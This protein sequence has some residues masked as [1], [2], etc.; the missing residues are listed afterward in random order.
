MNHA[1]TARA[2]APLVSLALLMGCTAQP[3]VTEDPLS[4]AGIESLMREQFDF[5]YDVEYA[6]RHGFGLI[7]RM[8]AS[9]DEAG[10]GENGSPNAAYRRSL[11]NS[12]SLAYQRS[13]EGDDGCAARAETAAMTEFEDKMSVIN[14]ATSQVSARITKDE[15]FLELDRN[16][17]SCMAE[18]GWDV[19]S[20]V[21]FEEGVSDEVFADLSAKSVRS[22]EGD[23]DVDQEVLEQLLAYERRAAMDH[24]ECWQ[25][26]AD[27]F[28]DVLR[29][30]YAT[31]VD[32]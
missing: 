9:K 23:G 2:T 16:W 29:D 18:R 4:Y 32:R 11:G 15:R 26:H 20:I 13:F 22:E 24:A 8:M 10:A 14:D 12:E 19:D 27:S 21:G 6:S 1:M 17:T 3:E 5:E 30:A 28:G 31:V 7:E 25:E